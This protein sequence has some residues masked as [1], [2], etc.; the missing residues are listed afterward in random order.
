V[1]C[2]NTV[3]ELTKA[4][5]KAIRI[6]VERQ[7]RQKIDIPILLRFGKIQAQVQTGEGGIIQ[8]YS[9][10]GPAELEGK[11]QHPTLNIQRPTFNENGEGGIRTLPCGGDNALADAA[12]RETARWRKFG[13]SVNDAKCCQNWHVLARF[14]GNGRTAQARLKVHS[15]SSRICR[16]CLSS[17]GWSKNISRIDARSFE[18]SPTRSSGGR[19]RSVPRIAVG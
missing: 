7:G 1:L 13:M 14:H 9:A 19:S 3:R 18:R 12:T 16:T 5:K 17:G 2:H 4:D 11:I 15:Q 8:S 6:S 10:L